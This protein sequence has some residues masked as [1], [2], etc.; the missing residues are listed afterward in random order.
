M[1]NEELFFSYTTDGWATSD[2]IWEC[3]YT[4]VSAGQCT[5]INPGPDSTNVF[6][7]LVTR[8][9]DVPGAGGTDRFTIQSAP[10]A[11]PWPWQHSDVG[12][13]GVAGDASFANGVFTVTGSGTDIWG[14]ADEFHYT[15]RSFNGGSGDMEMVTRVDSVQNAHAW[16]KAG[17]MFRSSLTADAVHASIF[18]TPGK[19]VA[20]QR[21]PAFGGTSLN[22]SVPGVPAP[23][24]L[25]LVIRSGVVAAYYRKSEVDAW[26]K[27]GDLDLTGNA[28]YGVTYAGLAVTSHV[29]GT[30]AA[31]TFANVAM[32]PWPIW[33]YGSVGL[34]V[35]S[36][37]FDESNATLT[38]RGTDIWGTSD[39]FSFLFTTW[40]GNGTTTA[41]V[42]HVD[43]THAWAKAGVMMRAT[44][45]EN[46]PHVMVVVTPGKGISMQYR[47]TTGGTS[48]QA[49][50]VPGVAPVWVRVTRSANAFTG[51]WSADGSTWNALGT[52]TVTMPPEV[53]TGLVLTSHNTT[54][55]ASAFFRVFSVRR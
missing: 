18:V 15:Y 33:S 52:I 7:T 49:A 8:D 14:A 40:D 12:A 47:A 25:R 26:T 55:T 5:W 20:F 9:A 37:T 32:T 27:V 3:M 1:A 23:V 36:A 41:L 16:T 31:S 35:A 21:R 6:V 51:A 22:T 38:S 28:A 46:S 45:R 48:T 42:T 50:Q 53:F 43:N 19:G 30:L 17:L 10:G 11:P 54:A 2:H 13:V 34:N 44:L 4:L 39:Q 29:D 24:W